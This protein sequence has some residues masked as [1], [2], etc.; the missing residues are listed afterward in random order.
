MAS[1]TPGANGTNQATTL[2][3]GLISDI[4]RAQILERNPQQNPSNLNYITSSSNDDLASFSAQINF[5]VTV[6]VGTDGKINIA[7]IDYFTPL[8][9]NTLNY[10][11]G[12]GGT[13]KSS[14]VQGAIIEQT[15]LLKN[16]ELDP[17]KNP[18]N[19]NYIIWS[20]TNGTIGGVGN[21]S[22]SASYN[23]MP[24]EISNLPD[25]NQSTIGKAYLL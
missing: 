23:N 15:I 11:V 22:F 19:A 18:T 4:R 24:L 6:T 12:T 7:A 8:S 13:I 2:E 3:A 21:A 14:T 5:P 17:A 25:G 9:G 16:L 1:R 10:T 20:L